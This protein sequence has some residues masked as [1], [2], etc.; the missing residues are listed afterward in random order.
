MRELCAAYPVQWVCEVWGCARSSFYYQPRLRQDQPVRNALHTLAGQ[1]PTYGARRL[2]AELRRQGFAV[3]R[4][5]VQRLMRQYGIV[6]QKRRKTIH[7]TQAG[8]GL[9]HYPNLVRHLTIVYP[10]QVWV[11]DITYI[12]L[13]TEVVYLAMV[14]DVF[15]RVIRG[16]HLSRGLDQGLSLEALTRA[17]REGCPEIHHSDQGV[18]Y[19]GTEYIARLNALQIQISMS[20]VGAAWQ[21]GYA[22]RFMR[23]LKEEE[24]A[25]AEYVDFTS[26]Y[27]QIGQFIDEVY[28]HKRI[29]SALG[30][31]TPAEYE[32]QWRAQ[33][34]AATQVVP[35]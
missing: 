35:F 6:P 18:Q 15:T 17:L 21:N 33:T 29:H 24:V 12:Q 2:T 10:N 22:E 25:L 7:T 8:Q 1:W 26:A 31:L 32:Q 19:A 4:K 11:A 23:T 13:R 16:W 14:M 34:G 20:D 28:R 5:R 3:N 9:R 27:Q 30:Y